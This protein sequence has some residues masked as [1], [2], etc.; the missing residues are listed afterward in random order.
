[1][2]YSY[3]KFL[4]QL[5]AKLR[6][7]RLERGWTLRDMIIKGFHLAQWQNFEKG[8]GVSVPS[9]LR[10]CEVFDLTTEELIGGLGTEE[11]LPETPQEKAPRVAAKR[12]PVKAAAK[13]SSRSRAVL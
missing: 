13:S 2:T 1:M 7:M 10:L 3:E 9:L 8:K 12:T 4:K 5:G 11:P 6:A